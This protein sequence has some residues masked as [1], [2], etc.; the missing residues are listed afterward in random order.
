MES[1]IGNFLFFNFYTRCYRQ[2]A[3]TVTPI[4]LKSNQLGHF[5]NFVAV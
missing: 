1:L 3:P 5:K 2:V 4:S